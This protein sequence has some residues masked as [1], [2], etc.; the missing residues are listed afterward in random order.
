MPIL[1]DPAGCYYILTNYIY[2]CL[3]KIIFV[4][5]MC[6]NMFYY[7]YF[8]Q[9][10]Q[11]YFGDENLG[12]FAALLLP[13]LAYVI[14]THDYDCHV[15]TDGLLLKEFSAW[16]FCLT[17]TQ[18]VQTNVNFG[19]KMSDVRPLFQALCTHSQTPPEV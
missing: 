7:L 15:K 17:K 1:K 13:K 2:K 14:Y 4:Q 8:K 11:K 10:M 12:K 19:Q 6:L 9:W 3:I 5:T 18:N 16:T